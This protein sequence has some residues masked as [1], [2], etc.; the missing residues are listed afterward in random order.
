[1]TPHLLRGFPTKPSTTSNNCFAAAERPAISV[2]GKKTPPRHHVFGYRGGLSVLRRVYVP[3]RQ[4][5]PEVSRPAASRRADGIGDLV[6]LGAGVLPDCADRGQADDHDEG[7][8]DRVFHGGRSIAFQSLVHRAAKIGTVPGERLRANGQPDS[9]SNPLP[10]P[11]RQS[12]PSWPRARNE[13][14][15]GRTVGNLG[16][17]Q[18]A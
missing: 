16:W 17:M 8:H 14:A 6:E 18:R 11:K 12:S 3:V 13:I 9:W 7:K 10:Q 1:M 2:Y 4:I 15:A 5:R